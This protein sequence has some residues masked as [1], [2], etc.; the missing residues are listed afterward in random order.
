MLSRMIPID[1]AERV[2]CE[3]VAIARTKFLS[4][5][6]QIAR[7]LLNQKEM[8]AIVKVLTEFILNIL[9]ELSGDTKSELVAI[10]TAHVL[11]ESDRAQL[12]ELRGKD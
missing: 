11:A 1:A 9:D 5:P 7:D 12:E 3:R 6:V 10:N 4:M 8:T 2:Y